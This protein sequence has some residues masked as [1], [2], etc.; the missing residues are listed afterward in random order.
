MNWLKSLLPL[1]PLV[2]AAL[3]R[4]LGVKPGPELKPLPAAPPPKRVPTDKK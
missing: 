1:L 3:A 2:G 4:A